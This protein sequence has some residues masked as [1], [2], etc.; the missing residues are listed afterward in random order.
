MRNDWLDFGVNLISVLL[1]TLGLLLAG[2]Q[3][4][5]KRFLSN[6]LRRINHL[7]KSNDSRGLG[8]GWRSKTG[9][10]NP[11]RRKKDGGN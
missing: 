9:K 4:E 7:L 6:V 10:E 2:Q 11:K 1:V 5:G 3:S 8:S